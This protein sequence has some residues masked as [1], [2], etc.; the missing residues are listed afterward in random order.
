MTKRKE[1]TPRELLSEKRET[2]EKKDITRVSPATQNT[3]F[4]ELIYLELQ[5]ILLA[6]EDIKREVS[7]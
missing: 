4:L 3:L 2:L 6:I 7:L 1:K 5:E